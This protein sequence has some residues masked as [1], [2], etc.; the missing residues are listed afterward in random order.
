MSRTRTTRT[1]IFILAAAAV[2]F[3]GCYTVILSPKTVSQYK[4][5]AKKPASADGEL[6]YY[7]D[8]RSCHSTAELNDRA[9]DMQH[10]GIR[11]VHGLP[12]DPYGWNYG[13]TAMTPWWNDSPIAP[14]P[15]GTAS[16]TK[17]PAAKTPATGVQDAGTTRGNEPT[18]REERPNASAPN[19]PASQ[20]ATPPT[21][22][23]STGTTATQQPASDT[24]KKERAR[25]T[26]ETPKPA[27]EKKKPNQD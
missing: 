14:L 13:P 26:G 3:A 15:A 18:R 12:V 7:D 21:P 4:E 8:C 6:N 11:I 1:I 20:P 9:Y 16:N 2:I 23:S 22:P 5:Y 27:E 24:S 25:D 10:A 17:T 19:A